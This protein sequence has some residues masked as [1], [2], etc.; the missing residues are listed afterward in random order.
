MDPA[1]PDAPTASPAEA[2]FV[3]EAWHSRTID[4]DVTGLLALY[5]PDAILESPLVPRVLDR[6]SGVLVGHDEIR[7]FL[8]RGTAGRPTGRARFFHRSDRYLFDGTTLCWEYPRATPGGDQTDLVEVMDLDGPLIRHHR[9]YWGWHAVPLLAVS[10]GGPNFARV[11][12]RD[13]PCRNDSR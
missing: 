12:D 7:E 3:H 4:H 2:R 10:L 13:C 6:D 9:I 8:D 5:R 1:D 11:S